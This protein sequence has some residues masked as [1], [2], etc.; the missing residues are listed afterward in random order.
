MKN[1]APTAKVWLTGVF[2]IVSGQQWSS[3]AQRNKIHQALAT[4]TILVS[5]IL[6]LL[7]LTIRK[8]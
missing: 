7:V 3:M 5:R 4:R 8:I 6:S 2:L 1:M